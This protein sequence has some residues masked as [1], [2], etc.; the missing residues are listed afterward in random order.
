[1][2]PRIVRV[3]KDPELNMFVNADLHNKPSCPQILQLRSD[4]VIC[5]ANAEY[6]LEHLLER[7]EEQT[8]P[9]KFLL[10]DLEAMGFIDITGIDELRVLH[11]K[12]TTR[13]IELALMGVRLPVRKVFDST[14]FTKELNA[15]HLIENRGDAI[16]RLFQHIDHEYCKS[17]CPYR[18]YIE[19]SGVK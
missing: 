17:I 13:G 10:L 2:H 3:T 8:T 5:F 16:S 15:E 14:G 6:T 7:V 12:L 18:L 9:V 19:C 4:N 11:D 1:M